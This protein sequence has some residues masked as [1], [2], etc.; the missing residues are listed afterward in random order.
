MRRV[1]PLFA[2]TLAACGV[3][4]ID[5]SGGSGDARSAI[6]SP[7][8]KKDASVPLP[9]EIIELDGGSGGG[10]GNEEGI[11]G[12]SGGGAGGTG[13]AG[14]GGGNEEPFGDAGTPDA[15][16]PE[17]T[18]G[19]TRPCTAICGSTG[20]QRCVADKWQTTCEPPREVCSNGRDDDCDGASD[21]RDLD[22]PP[23]VVRCET[24]EGNT[25]N[26]DEG[27]GDHCAASWNTG[28]CSA[29]RFANWC[30]RRNPATPDRWDEYIANWVD[31]RC[32]G[33]LVSDG[34]TFRCRSSANVQYECTTPLV[35]V[36]EGDSVALERSPG[37]F[38]FT[39]GEPAASDWPVAVNPW[40]VRDVNGNGRIDDG[41]ELFGS[42]TRVGDVRAAHGFEA[43]APLDANH[44][45]V[46]DAKDPAFAGLMLWSDGNADRVSQPAEL[47]SLAARGVK[48]LSVSFAVRARCDARGNCERER[49]AFTWAD[50]RGTHS[51]AIVDVYLRVEP[52][53]LACR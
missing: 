14:G 39:P 29:E 31:S 41:S 23:V 10:G 27:Y 17:C 42:S 21:S 34:A 32:D 40:L 4:T 5:M 3:S 15:G 45:G 16:Q 24:S 13:G 26:G 30:N 7:D 47:V 43:L 20:V 6:L 22:C 1:L 37:R 48:S 28:G 53:A 9:G 44:D 33:T 52:S 49:G 50:Q 46:V 12:G 36:F 51:G 11:G 25:C 38:A 2:A 8:A 19:A 18:P 35:L